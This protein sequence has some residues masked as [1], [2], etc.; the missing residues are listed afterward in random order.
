MA[1]NLTTPSA[2]RF[3][4]G[5]DLGKIVLDGQ[6]KPLRGDSSIRG[7]AMGMTAWK[8]VFRI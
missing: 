6:V 3:V 5:D 4:T 7:E 1:M 8:L 2:Y